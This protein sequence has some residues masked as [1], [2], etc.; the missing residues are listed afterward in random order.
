MASCCF[1]LRR[2]IH[3][4]FIVW[5]FPQ[6]QF[7]RYVQTLTQSSQFSY[8][9]HIQSMHYFLLYTSA[10]FLHTQWTYFLRSS[11]QFTG[12]ALSYFFWG[13]ALKVLRCS[14]AGSLSLDI[15]SGC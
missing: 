9:S 12:L 2:E 7:K 3:F 4:L 13:P 10:S 1:A 15:L 6:K 8:F 14:H 11:R 5:I